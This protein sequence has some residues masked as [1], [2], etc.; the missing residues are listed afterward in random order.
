MPCPVLAGSVLN[1]LV[2]DFI[3]PDHAQ[4]LA[5][6]LGEIGFGAFL[7]IAFHFPLPDRFRWDFWRWVALLPAALCFMHALTLW[8]R[9][10]A[11]VTLMPW[12]SAIGAESD[13]DMNRLVQQFGWGANELAGLYLHAAYVAL[14]VLAA[15]YAYSAYRLRR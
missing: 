14:A 15:T 12:G 13:G 7:L 2:E 4:I 5:G 9:V 3:V 6:A 10:A 1:Y 8:R 11:D